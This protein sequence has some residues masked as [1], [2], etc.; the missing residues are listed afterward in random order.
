LK[1]E[2]PEVV[3]EL[4]QTIAR[5]VRPFRDHI[6]RN[7]TNWCVVA[8]ASA[9]WAARVF[10][11]LPADQQVPALW[12]AIVR[13]CRLDDR[14]PVEAWRR[15]IEALAGRRDYLNNRRYSSLR[16]RG[17]GTDLEIGLPDG[18]LWVSAQSVSRQGITFTANIPTEEVFTMPHKDRVDGTVHGSKPVSHGG[19]LIDGFSLTFS[20]GRIVDARAE[21]G[22]AVLRQLVETDPG[23]SR[24]GEI[25]L[26]PDNSPISRSGLLFYNT[27]FDENAASH[28]A[29]GS[30]Y[31]F[32]LEGGEV[33]SGD[34]FGQAGGNQSATHVDLMIGSALLDIDGI[35]ADGTVEPLMRAGDWA[36]EVG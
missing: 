14:D 34:A 16:Y 28:I 4:Q 12:D 27:L 9:S 22:E 32:T 6:S 17:P 21:R 31:K 33:M 1:N 13:L 26:V 7:H 25:A 10:P 20:E 5:S 15:H 18:H 36:F 30:A 8:A 24:L 3:G 23:A 11:G 2:P 29:I 19:M 35:R